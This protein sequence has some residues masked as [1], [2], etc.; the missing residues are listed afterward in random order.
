MTDSNREVVFLAA[1]DNVVQA[2]QVLDAIERL[3]HDEMPG[4]YDAA[5]VDKINGKTRIARRLDRPLMRIIP[6]HLGSGTLPRK[7][8]KE[9]AEH[10]TSV[11]AG[12][13]VIAEPAVEEVIGKTIF[14]AIRVTRVLVDAT[15]GDLASELSEA[16]NG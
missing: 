7:E 15:A 8:L 1:F 6:E 10:L 3:G 16:L 11:E 14:G 13:I 9:A 12:L 4:R 5:V 2:L